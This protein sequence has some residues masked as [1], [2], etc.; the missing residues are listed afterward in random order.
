MLYKRGNTWWAKWKHEGQTFYRSTG[1][2]NKKE[3][4]KREREFK[5]ESATELKPRQA[6]KVA[7]YLYS[8]AI[9]KWKS[10]SMPKSMESHAR[11]TRP[12]LDHVQL[13]NVPSATY[14]MIA[15]MQQRGLSN[16]T[17]N[18]RI[19]VVKRVLNLAYK[20]WDWLEKDLATKIDKLSEKGLAREIYLSHD[21]FDQLVSAV[22]NE[23]AR[24]VLCL[25]VYTG[26][27]MGEIYA[28]NDTSWHK[29]YIVLHADM[30]KSGKARTV[31]L[32]DDLHHLMDRLPLKIHRESV[33]W[34]FE[35][36]RKKIGREEI[37]MHD[38]RHSYA[39]WIA[40][41][42]DIALTTLR[43][44]LGHSSLAVTSKYAHL[45]GNTFEAVSRTLKGDN[46]GDSLAT[47]H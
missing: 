25:A 34:Y 7:G 35:K 4:E 31:P 24:D 2:T 23:D 6:K 43:D 12:Y 20:K 1:S 42:P 5:K 8:N 32:I 17:I 47:A 15:D 14:D 41:N 36:A 46:G 21:E 11:N 13:E 3:A 30:T 45:Q 10:T 19:A 22:D 29:P 26:M 16:Q 28:L 9:L 44:L 27:R 33:R 37:R 39:S 18:R 40:T 38:L